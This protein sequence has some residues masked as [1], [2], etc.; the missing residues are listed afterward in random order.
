MK[1]GVIY[2]QCTH[3]SGGG[4]RQLAGIYFYKEQPRPDSAKLAST[5]TEATGVSLTQ[6]NASR[7]QFFSLWLQK[8]SPARARGQGRRICSPSQ[9]NTQTSSVW[10][11]HT[12]SFH[13]LDQTCAPRRSLSRNRKCRSNLQ[14]NTA[15]KGVGFVLTSQA[16]P[17]VWYCAPSYKQLMEIMGTACHRLDKID[18]NALVNRFTCISPVEASKNSQH[19]DVRAVTGAALYNTDPFYKKPR[20]A[21]SWH[22]HQRIIFSTSAPKYCSVDSSVACGL[23]V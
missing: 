12:H 13:P 4:V 21:V 18:I 6:K 5:S 8:T 20:H 9:T 16:A 23:F 15:A 1:C 17:A 7:P 19:T 14:L 3:H 2:I 11:L 22:A 10:Y